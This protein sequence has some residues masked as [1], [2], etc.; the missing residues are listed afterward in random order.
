MLTMVKIRE[1]VQISNDRLGNVFQFKEAVAYSDWPLNISADWL[2]FRTQKSG[3]HWRRSIADTSCA[4]SSALPGGFRACYS[5][6]FSLNGSVAALTRRYP[7][8]GR[9]L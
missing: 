3:S 6:R 7:W 4:C 8:E 1:F 5:G 2:H 9:I